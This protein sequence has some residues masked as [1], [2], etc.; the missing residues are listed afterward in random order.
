[1]VPLFTV[2][3]AFKSYIKT[4]L[5]PENYFKA[6]S[7]ETRLRCIM[8]LYKE[9]ELCVCELT[10]ALELSQPK[11]SRHLAQLRQSRL[12]VDNRSSQWIYYKINPEL[13]AWALTVLSE[14]EQAM[15]EVEIYQQDRNRLHS[16]ASKLQNGCG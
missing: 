13:P 9:G 12:L 7:D 10:T 4:M 6:L 16:L 3:L 8:L 11:I 15:S 5:L 1:V 2:I 14:T